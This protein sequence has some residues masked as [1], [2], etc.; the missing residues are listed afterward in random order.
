MLV[1]SF[2]QIAGDADVKDG[3][4]LIGQDIDEVLPFHAGE[5]ASLRSQ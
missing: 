2:L 5:I 4:V 3:V 1:D